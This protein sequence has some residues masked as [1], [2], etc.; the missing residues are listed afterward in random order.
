MRCLISKLYIDS[1]E[2]SGKGV[3][4]FVSSHLKKCPGCSAYNTL[5]HR[6]AGSDPYSVFS[7]TAISGL[8]K[9]IS[10][11][12]AAGKIDKRKQTGFR[13]F[14]PL[15][16][17]ALFFIAVISLGIILFQ[18]IKQPSDKTVQK[19][20]ITMAEAGNINNLNTLLAK[21]ES[22]IQQE[23]EDLKKTIDSAR[24]YLRSVMDFGLP[25]IPE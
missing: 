19:K 12:L 10:D 2:G 13:L 6:L 4:G 9:T 3:P 17:A 22:P 7:D 14:S 15:A 11:S 5:G 16:L 8:N 21:V 20:L 1:R 25:G 24:K 18:G 23:A